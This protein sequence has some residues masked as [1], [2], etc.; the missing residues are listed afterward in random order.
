MK[1][2]VAHREALQLLLMNLIPLAGVIGLGWDPVLIFI[3]YALETLV[4][5]LFNLPKIFLTARQHPAGTI[6]VNG[7]QQHYSALGLM[8]F[9]TAH[10]GFFVFV[11]LTI[12]FGI[13]SISGY[14][15]PGVALTDS[16][17]GAPGNIARLAGT[18]MGIVLGFMG[19]SY[20]MSFISD[21]V[22][23]NKAAKMTPAA[24]M[25]EP[26]PRIFVQQFVVI[27][28]GWIMVIQFRSLPFLILFVLVK[29]MVDYF[30]L[31]KG[32]ELVKTMRFE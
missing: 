6:P 13:L 30:M 20:L 27:L 9:F 7:K 12:F 26:Y 32:P 28:A 2:T 18:E 21:Y 22:F 14:D 3:F 23:G 4:A 25:F 11:Q 29:T 15:I 8:L 24:Q 1:R 5:G 19:F 17:F 10:Y 31:R 16:F